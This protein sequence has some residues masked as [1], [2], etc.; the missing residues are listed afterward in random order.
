MEK[1]VEESSKN[2][3]LAP[4]FKSIK[5]RKVEINNNTDQSTTDIVDLSTTDD[6]TAD[7]TSTTRLALIDS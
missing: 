4:I 5:K 7:T 3:T 1:P 2:I 6:P